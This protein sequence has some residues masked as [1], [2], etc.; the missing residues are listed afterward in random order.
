MY[1]VTYTASTGWGNWQNLGGSL[2]GGF[3]ATYVPQA[4]ST[5]A[6]I[7]STA[8]GQEGYTDDPAGTYCNKYTF[9]WGAGSTLNCAKGT[10]SEEWCSDF[11][12]WVWEMSGVSL[13]YGSVEGQDVNGQV[14][15]FYLWGVAHGTW[16]AVGSGYTPQPGDLAVYGLDTSTQYAAHIA[17][18]TSYT[19]GD[20]GPN[21]VNG[22]YN[23]DVQYVT[24]ETSN[25]GSGNNLAGYV[26]P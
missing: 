14:Y 6:L 4:S 19:P 20:A 15:H 23:Y 1:Q 2:E 12:A 18:V 26:S 5:A 8:E 21:A 16:H 22:D 10:S 3:N 11:A 25:T 24:D 7:V 13:T 9:Y 17:V